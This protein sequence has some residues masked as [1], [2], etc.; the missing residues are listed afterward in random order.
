MYFVYVIYVCNYDCMHSSIL[1]KSEWQA[2][3]D[4]TEE[5]LPYFC[6]MITASTYLY[7]IMVEI[8]GSS[9]IV[10]AIQFFLIDIPGLRAVHWVLRAIQGFYLYSVDCTGRKVPIVRSRSSLRTTSF[11]FNLPPP[12]YECACYDVY[13]NFGGSWK[14]WWCVS[15][16]FIVW[17]RS[18]LCEWSPI[19]D[20][21]QFRERHPFD[22]LDHSVQWSCA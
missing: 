14:D 20:R 11:S 3:Q 4:Y 2:I 10:N 8:L 6:S 12:K 15:S 9:N 17:Y 16:C 13:R 1:L 19:D 21:G 22:L 18:R 5:K 7:E